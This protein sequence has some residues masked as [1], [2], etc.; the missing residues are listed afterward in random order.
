MASRFEKLSEFLPTPAVWHVEEHQQRLLPRDEVLAWSLWEDLRRELS[1][2]R[3]YSR[4]FTVVR[5][6]CGRSRTSGRRARGRR[7]TD[8]D[9]RVR[10]LTS[11]VRDIDRVW[12]HGANVYLLLPECDRSMAEGLL[13][14]IRRPLSEQLQ[15]EEAWLACFPEDAVASGALL[16]VLL[17][18]PVRPQPSVFQAAE[19]GES[20]SGAGA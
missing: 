20:P 6:P 5:L 11:L 3:R 14:R 10:I 4:S 17:G 2:S 9:E 7:M 15:A 13:S 16:A 1:R 18:V 8:E 12:A 19:G